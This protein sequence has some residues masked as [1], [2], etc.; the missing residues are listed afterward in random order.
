ME[1]VHSWVDKAALERRSERMATVKPHAGDMT[2]EQMS[3]RLDG[4]VL[5]MRQLEKANQNS[6]LV[7][8]QLKKA[9]S[10]MQSSDAPQ[11]RFPSDI[12]QAELEAGDV[13]FIVANLEDESR[14][15]VSTTWSGYVLH[16]VKN[17]SDSEYHMV[18][19][20]RQTTQGPKILKPLADIYRSRAEAER[21]LNARSSAGPKNLAGPRSSRQMKR[22][23]PKRNG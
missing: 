17:E 9:I 10:E 7:V 12:T 21:A 22:I 2:M 4:L 13:F 5:R 1:D 19:T 16:N 15:V 11:S 8:S 3:D 23:T 18:R 6:M 20:D 14:G